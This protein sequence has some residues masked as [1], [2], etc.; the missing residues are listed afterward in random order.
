MI[1]R[2]GFYLL[3]VFLIKRAE[4]HCNR[5]PL[6]LPLPPLS[7]TIIAETWWKDENTIHKITDILR[8]KIKLKI[9]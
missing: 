5:Q 7:F 1:F 3:L 2:S 4:M 6:P 8:E 9:S